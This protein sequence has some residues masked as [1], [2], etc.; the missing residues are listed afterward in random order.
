MSAL[1]RV[2]VQ[3]VEGDQLVCRVTVVYDGEPLTPSRTLS[4]RFIWEPWWDLTA[5]RADHLPNGKGVSKDQAREM[6]RSAPLARE[7]AEQDMDDLDWC[8]ANAA[9]FVRCVGVTDFFN[10]DPMNEEAPQEEVAPQAT[11][12]ILVT[13]PEWLAHLGP[14]MEWETHGFDDDTYPLANSKWRSP[15]VMSLARAI[16]LSQD[17]SG[18][19]VL[20]DAL[21][22]AGCDAEPILSHLRDPACRH[23]R[24]C[25]AF[26]RVLGRF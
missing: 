17:F 8:C 14:G 26:E 15:D 12:T 7:L 13:D 19:P 1:Y 10:Y 20:A 16:D 23:A 3:S 25:W 21:Q 22:E 18:M 24:G 11:Y 6:G 5:G 9:R 2:R 4:F